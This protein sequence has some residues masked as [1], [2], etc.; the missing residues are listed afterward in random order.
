[1]N[2]LFA[3][4]IDFAGSETERRKYYE[5][6]TTSL[7][8]YFFK[9]INKGLGDCSSFVNANLGH[10]APTHDLK[11]GGQYNREPTARPFAYDLLKER[12]DTK[13]EGGPNQ[14]LPKKIQRP[15]VAKIK[16]ARKVKLAQ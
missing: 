4:S 2:T 3:P 7:G 11:E 15:T 14:N 12:K 9:L 8:Q 16:N 5:P 10:Q 1:M 13:K 6:K